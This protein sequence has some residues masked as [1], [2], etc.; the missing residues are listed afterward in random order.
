MNNEKI[1]FYEIEE[2][3]DLE[4]DSKETLKIIQNL[5]ADILVID[6]Y[7]IESKWERYYHK[8]N[9]KLVIDDLTNRKH[10]GY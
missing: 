4:N 5:N 3:L 1:N 10:Y 2:Q 9:I 6:S 7:A 8:L